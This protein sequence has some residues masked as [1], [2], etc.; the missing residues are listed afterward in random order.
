MTRHGLLWICTLFLIFLFAPLMLKRADYDNCVHR[1]LAAAQTWYG[2]QEVDTILRRTNTLYGMMMIHTGIDPLIRQY[3]MKPDKGQKPA[4]KTQVPGEQL[5]DTVTPYTEQLVGYGEHFLYNIWMFF[6]RIAHSWSW[7]IY[8]TPFMAAITFDGI[9]TR[10]AKLAS[11]KYTSPTIYNMS[12][13]TIIALAA[14]SLV[15]F[16]MTFVLPV[17][18]YPIVITIMGIQLRL[19]I[20]NIQHSA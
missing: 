12:W 15:A 2:D 10:K 6:F 14:I 1:E 13:H 16:A 19:L 5:L 9:M 8:L 18:F 20:S 3:F 4:E 11:F 17:I 7:F